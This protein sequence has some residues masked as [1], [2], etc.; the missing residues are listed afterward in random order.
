MLQHLQQKGSAVMIMVKQGE[1]Q[2]VVTSFLA[3]ICQSQ[4][5]YLFT[6]TSFSTFAFVW[7]WICL[8]G[9]KHSSVVAYGHAKMRCGY[10]VTLRRDVV[11][12]SREGEILLF[13]RQGEVCLSG[14]AKMRPEPV[15]DHTTRN[16]FTLKRTRKLSASRV[17]GR[18][19]SGCAVHDVNCLV[20]IK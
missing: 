7:T 12:L 14:H 15:K 10:V 6:V 9:A 19:G 4:T 8:D 2:T 18:F 16:V 3:C 17:D 20:L 1:D 5:S 13:S 11:G